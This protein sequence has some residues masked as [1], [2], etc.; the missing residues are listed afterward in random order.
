VKEND[1]AINVPPF[2]SWN[3][4]NPDEDEGDEIYIE[5]TTQTR[6]ENEGSIAKIL[7]KEDTKSNKKERKSMQ[8]PAVSGKCHKSRNTVDA[9]LFLRKQQSGISASQ[10]GVQNRLC[11]TLTVDEAL[12]L[13]GKRKKHRALSSVAIG[14]PPPERR[15]VQIH[16]QDSL[17]VSLT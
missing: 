17:L 12:E 3:I 11:R 6:K 2:C 9:N 13:A 15:H 8:E 4:D 7:A 10:S 16:H 1:P 5:D 14:R